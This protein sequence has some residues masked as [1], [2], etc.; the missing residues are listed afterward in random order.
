MDTRVESYLEA[1]ADEGM[2]LLEQLCR[3][4][5]IAAQNLGLSEMAGLVE[6]LLEDAGFAT[7]QLQV[8]TDGWFSNC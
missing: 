3:Q 2:S 5:S 6:T 1:H 7:R 8:M 4:P